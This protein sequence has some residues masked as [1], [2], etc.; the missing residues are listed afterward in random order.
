MYSDVYSRFEFT[1]PEGGSAGLDGTVER[2]RRR[3]RFSAYSV[4]ARQGRLTGRSEES[5]GHERVI[6]TRAVARTMQIILPP[7]APA[8]H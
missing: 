5:L 4:D 1:Q 7:A 3:S 8:P 6:F 2:S